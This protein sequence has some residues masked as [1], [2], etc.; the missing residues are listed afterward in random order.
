M[1]KEQKGQQHDQSLREN[2]VLQRNPAANRCQQIFVPH[3]IRSCVRE[4]IFLRSVK[5][6]FDMRNKLTETSLIKDE[7]IFLLES[8]EHGC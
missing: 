1:E 4:Q 8:F 3:A 2:Y 6:R 5:K 7:L